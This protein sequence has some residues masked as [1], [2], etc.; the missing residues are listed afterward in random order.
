MFGKRQLGGLIPETGRYLMH[1]GEQVVPAHKAGMSG[2]TLNI[3]GNTFLDEDMA[4]RVGDLIV[5]KLK[6][7]I[8]I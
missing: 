8:R 5:R 1:R 3:T 4:E 7:Q 2:I 6:S